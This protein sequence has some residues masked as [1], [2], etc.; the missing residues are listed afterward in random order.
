MI[1]KD[2]QR[3]Y[4]QFD[5]NVI[6]FFL[7]MIFFIPI[8]LVFTYIFEVDQL[9]NIN[10]F[11]FWLLI[12]NFILMLIGFF[13]LMIRKE[14]LIRQVKPTYRVEFFYVI[15]LF[16]FGILGFIVLYDY[17]GGNRKYIANILVVVF[18]ASVYA[19]IYLGKKYFKFYYMKK[20]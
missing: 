5:I 12:T 13:S 20:K 7:S 18:V 11:M 9:L 17:M 3:I 8:V 19:L 6:L 16:S 10:T 15:L 1:K 4:S 14:K 2:R